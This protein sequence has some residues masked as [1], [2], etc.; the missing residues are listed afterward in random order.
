MYAISEG[1]VKVRPWLAV[2]WNIKRGISPNK[3]K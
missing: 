1:V 3:M 2:G